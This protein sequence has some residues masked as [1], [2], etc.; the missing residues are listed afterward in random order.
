MSKLSEA[1]REETV[2]RFYR[3][4]LW[5]SLQIVSGLL[6]IWDVKVRGG[7]ENRVYKGAKSKKP[8]TMTSLNLVGS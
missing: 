3:T 7:G 8:K 4:N 5:S 6:R 1:Q 2:S